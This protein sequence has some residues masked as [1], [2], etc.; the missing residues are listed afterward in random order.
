MMI[1]QKE[2]SYKIVTDYFSLW[3]TNSADLLSDLFDEDVTLFD[4]NVGV[5]GK[6]QVIKA[7]QDIFDS[8]KKI[9]ITYNS[10]DIGE[11]AIYCDLLIKIWHT[12]VDTEESP[13]EIIEVMDVI[14]INGHGKIQSIKAYKG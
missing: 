7:N 14:T 10:I 8:V 4:W 9:G 1:N 2:E 5:V 11:K 6:S 3:N 13:S 12:D